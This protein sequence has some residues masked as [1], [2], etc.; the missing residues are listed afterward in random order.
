VKR[1]VLVVVWI[2]CHSD[3]PSIDEP[4]E[5]LGS[6]LGHAVVDQTEDRPGF[7]GVLD[8]AESAE[9]VAPY[10]SSN[11]RLAV[12]LG[13]HVERG[14]LIVKLDDRQLQQELVEARAQQR[15]AEAAIAQADVER[16]SAEVVLDRERRAEAEK[17]GSHADVLAAD[18]G[19]QKAKAAI[20]KARA[21]VGEQAARVAQLEAHRL[22]MTVVA[23]QTGSVAMVYIA[24]GSRVE[25][26][27]PMVKLISSDQ[28]VVKFAIPADRAATIRIGD[29]VDMQIDQH[30]M[31][32]AVVRHVAPDL[33]GVAQMILADAEIVHPTPDLKSGVVCRIVP[34]PRP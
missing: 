8:A 10:T 7:V 25:A 29:H 4:L 11:A 30:A 24:D 34:R 32:E 6:D 21:A 19:V 13:D 3:T 5:E 9:L 18:F 1:L 23:P 17:V 15:T 27:H 26:G 16:R 12:K 31:A 14:Q 2:G 33:D 20:Q 22:E 28:L